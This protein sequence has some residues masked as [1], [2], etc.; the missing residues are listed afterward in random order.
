MT[1]HPILAATLAATTILSAG[2]PVAAQAASSERGGAQEAAV[3]GGGIVYVPP[4]RGAPQGRIGGSTRGPV[5]GLPSLEVLAPDHA[6]LTASPQPTLLWYLGA[7]AK[8]P[9]EIVVDTVEMSGRPPL[10]DVT[11]QRPSPGINA[12]DLA[13]HKVRL[14]PG[15]LY[16]WS[17]AMQVDPAQRSGDVL[18]SGMIVYQTGASPAV[19]RKAPAATAA[20]RLAAQG[21]WY[22]ALAVLSR[23]IAGQPGDAGLRDL[24][25]SLLEQV[26]LRE[27]AA[28]DRAGRRE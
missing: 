10:L 18:A 26:G 17:V 9:I 16:R 12:V 20:S 21:Y 27:P 14:E 22:D 23:A 5:G 19:D 4:S 13:Q 1:R 7:P 24:R 6:G 28:Y 8:G 2:L 11:L 3:P 15:R 25:A